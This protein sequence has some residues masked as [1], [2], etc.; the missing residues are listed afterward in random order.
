M[1]KIIISFLALILSACAS[2]GPRKAESLSNVATT[3]SKNIPSEQSDGCGYAGLAG[4]EYVIT[5]F[6]KR[7]VTNSFFYDLKS[8][9]YSQTN[10]DAYLPLIQHP[11][12]MLDNTLESV[13]T[14][15]YKQSYLAQYRYF[16]IE[17]DGKIYKIDKTKV[18]AF[19]TSDCHIYYQTRDEG[20]KGYTHNFAR[21]DGKSISSEDVARFFNLTSVDNS[22]NSGNSLVSFV[23]IVEKDPYLKTVSLTTK[24][25]NGVLLRAAYSEK[26]KKVSFIQL[27][28]DAVFFD[29]WAH[30]QAAYDE[31]GNEHKLVKISTDVDCN[32]S[33]M[34]GCKLT[35]TVGISLTHDFLKKNTNGFTIKAIGTREKIISVPKDMVTGMLNGLGKL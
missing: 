19:V 1:K 6:Y 34:F 11:F 33:D 10:K 31:D 22:V 2:T 18:T 32:H 8:E 21:T 26:E 28:A 27:Y 13:E 12:K 35:E 30:L 4:P 24:A 5:D 15:K 3:G 23:P 20:P 25:Y 7:Y 29:K 9:K 14:N 16:D 17:L